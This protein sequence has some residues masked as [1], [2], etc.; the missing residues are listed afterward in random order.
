MLTCVNYLHPTQGTI[1]HSFD[2]ANACNNFEDQL[3]SLV[4]SNGNF[5]SVFSSPK[6]FE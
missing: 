1:P 3:L 6:S 4:L 2:D 5:I